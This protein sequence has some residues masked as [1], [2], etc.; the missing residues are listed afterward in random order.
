MYYYY[1]CIIIITITIIIIMIM[2]II[3]IIITSTLIIS[4]PTRN[5]IILPLTVPV[6]WSVVGPVLEEPVLAFCRVQSNWS[7]ATFLKW[8]KSEPKSQYRAG[9]HFPSAKLMSSSAISPRYEDPRKPSKTS[10]KLWVLD[11]VIWAWRHLL[12]W[13]P[14]RLQILWKELNWNELK[15]IELN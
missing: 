2:I 15:W 4:S 14:V 11:R 12:P 1:A 6:V 10:V 5:K 3:M 7:P 9:G 8:Q 13:V